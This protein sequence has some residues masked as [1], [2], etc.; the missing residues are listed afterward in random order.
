MTQIKILVEHPATERFIAISTDDVGQVAVGGGK[1][2]LEAINDVKRKSVRRLGTHELEY[3]I[4][5]ME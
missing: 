2:R 4:N 5:D 1:T 3:E